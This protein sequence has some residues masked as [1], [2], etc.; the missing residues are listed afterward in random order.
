MA[1]GQAARSATLD[2]S[3]TRLLVLNLSPS[4]WQIELSLW[5]FG[6]ATIRELA[7]DLEGRLDPRSISVLLRRMEEKGAVSSE[8]SG[9]EHLF[10]PLLDREAAIGEQVRRFLDEVLRRQP[11]A[12]EI[13][14]REIERRLRLA[15]FHSP[16]AVS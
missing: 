10:T 14:R 16:E 7:G 15:G 3:R 2:S 5:K 9:R 1:S 13:C 8:R 12:L 11:D 4:E 6:H